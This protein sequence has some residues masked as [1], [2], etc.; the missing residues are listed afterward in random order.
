MNPVPECEC[1]EVCL[2]LCQVDDLLVDSPAASAA[3]VRAVLNGEPGPPRDQALLNA[4]AALVVAGRVQELS[5]GITM[6][7]RAIDEGNAIETL[8]QWKQ[9]AGIRKNT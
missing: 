9:L 8:N 2:G 6:A 1:Y 5:E 4:G 3:I 7:A